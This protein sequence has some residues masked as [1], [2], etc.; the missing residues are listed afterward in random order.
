MS[1]KEAVKFIWGSPAQ[2][3][4]ARAGTNEKCTVLLAAAFD[5][6][7]KW[8]E[9]LRA[10]DFSSRKMNLYRHMSSVCGF[11]ADLSFAVGNYLSSDAR[12]LFIFR[13]DRCCFDRFADGQTAKEEMT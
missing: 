11:F 10:I 1:E 3:V 8:I 9:K 2:T 13:I 5:A 6:N 7:I 12:S 4:C